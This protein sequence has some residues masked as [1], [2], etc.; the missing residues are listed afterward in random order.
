MAN[1]RE[2]E[3][4]EEVLVGALRL[5]CDGDNDALRRWVQSVHPDALRS[6]EYA[7]YGLIAIAR[8]ELPLAP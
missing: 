5:Y 2:S 8:R 3:V 1:R 7:G 6:L 4:R